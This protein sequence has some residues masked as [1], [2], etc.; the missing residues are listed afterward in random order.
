VCVSVSV[1]ECEVSLHEY[2]PDAHTQIEIK[3][4]MCACVALRVHFRTMLCVR[5]ATNNI[6][7]LSLTNAMFWPQL[8]RFRAILLTACE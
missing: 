1:F 4:I 7:P 2:T 8:Y 5:R 3:M 6:T